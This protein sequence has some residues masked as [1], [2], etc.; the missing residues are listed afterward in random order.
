MRQKLLLESLDADQKKGAKGEQQASFL[1]K[2]VDRI[3]NNLKI[4]IENVYFRF[5]DKLLSPPPLPN[6]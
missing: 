5:E 4:S 6:P 1:N 2:L 3:I